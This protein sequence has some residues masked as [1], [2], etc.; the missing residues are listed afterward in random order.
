MKTNVINFINSCCTCQIVGKPNQNIPPYPLR[1]IQ[2]PCESFSKI[3][4]DVV[5]PLLRTKKR[6]QY[7]L[8][9]MCPTTRYSE[10]FPWKNFDGKTIVNN[11]KSMFTTYGIPQEVQNYRGTNFTNNLRAAF[12]FQLGITQTH[13]TAYHQSQG[14]LEGCHQTLK[15]IIR[16]FCHE[17]NQDQEIALSFALLPI[18]ETPNKT[19]GVFPL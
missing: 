15:S 9:I 14:A 6:N 10:A 19:L 8:T 12:L 4:I 5:S 11:L 7:I 16:K 3:I 17:N 1:P 2:V 13:Y 18:R